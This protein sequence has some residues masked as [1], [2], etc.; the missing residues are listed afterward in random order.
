MRI[1]DNIL[2]LIIVLKIG[3]FEPFNNFSWIYIISAL[4]VLLIVKFIVSV[5]EKAGALNEIRTELAETYLEIR[6]SQIAKQ[7]IKKKSENEKTRLRTVKR[8]KTI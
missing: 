5:F 7:I 2:V 1:L 4:V 8:K 3:N 6:A